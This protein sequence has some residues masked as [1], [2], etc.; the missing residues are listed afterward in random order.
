MITVAIYIKDVDTLDYNRIDLF[1]DEKISVTS[2]I[3]NINDIS[4][5]FT[6]FSQTFTVP[7]SKQNNKIFRHW[8]DNSNDVP[9]STLVKSD[10]YIEIDTITFRKGKI[11]LES[12]N[13]EDGQAKD[14]SI[15]FI[16]ILGN[17]KDKFAGKF[18]KDLILNTTYDYFNYTPANVLSR[19]TTATSSDIMFPLISSDRY[20]NYGSAVDLVNDINSSTYP[21]RYNELFPAL[22]L[23][24]VLNIIETEFG[25]NFDGTATEPSNFINT[26]LRFTN[27]YLYMKNAETFVAIK[28]QTKN[29]FTTE[30]ATNLTGFDIDLAT[31]KLL[32]NF[33]PSS[34]VVSS[35]TYNLQARSARISITTSTPGIVFTL[36]V[37]KNG[38]K[39]YESAEET[40]TVSGLFFNG[41][42]YLGSD[43]NS[44]TDYY[45]FYVNTTASMTFTSFFSAQAIYIDSI[46]NQ[47]YRYYTANGVAQTTPTY[48]LPIKSYFPE[49][50]VEDFFS[51]L[52]KMFNLT[53]FSSDGINYTVE[54]LETY[55][56]NGND[57]DITK[58]V[59]QDKKALNRV[60]TYKKINFEYEKSESLVN[61]GFNSANGVEYGSLL[62]NTNNDGD[63]YFIKLP[64][65]DLNFNNLQDKL[66]V[67]YA[68][69]T[70]LQKYTPKP[71]ILYDYDPTALTTLT[72]TNFKFSTALTG[73]GSNTT[74]TAYK[75]FGQET[76]ISGLTYGL[77]F[78]T[79]ESTLTNEII[80]NGLY[81]QYYENYFNNIFNFKAR[82]VKVSAILPTSVLTT[83]KL[84][85]NVIIRDTKYLINTFTTDLTT[86]EVQ[87]EL[88]TDQRLW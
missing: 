5:T 14:Y 58:Y 66:Q 49:I 62:Y 55:Y 64:F 83:L 36:S 30:S 45:E 82:L 77:N 20:W 86:G 39:I 29:D 50:K 70:D 81:K 48:F 63:E 33:I 25:I 7:A 59:I 23:R 76:L 79:Q 1:D 87:F 84:N 61:V 51:G 2:S 27:S 13:L 8:Y 21:I 15:T 41:G 78:G 68:L 47:I 4:K 43:N 16:G 57:V 74:V 26:D 6:D 56:G 71:I 24:A 60:K 65:E 9:F 35:V 22:K 44:S 69:K 38:K 3:Q 31:D 52:L 54:Q 37:F 88:L 46:G 85:D 53:C 80:E 32:I 10:A 18:L 28:N 73:S 12:A 11:Q 75:A 40:S 34:I 67:G 17:L 72:S 42:I 19:I